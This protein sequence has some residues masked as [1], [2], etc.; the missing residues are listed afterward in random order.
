MALIAALLCLLGWFLPLSDY[1]TPKSGVG[2]WMGI[3]GASM[4]LLLLTY[5]L[6]KRYRFLDW[7]P[8]L[9][10]WFNLHIFLG[11]Y[12]PLLIL[13][14]CGYHL[15]A[16]N[17]NMALWSMITVAVSGVIGRFLYNRSEFKRAFSIWHVA[18]L[19]F[20]FMLAAA[21]IVHIIAVNMY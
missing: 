3:V 7:T 2:Y 6:R 10:K 12:G 11:L 9:G 20:V 1:L 8:P 4:M 17:S 19:P 14:H 5:S 16:F 13:Y 21:A 15:G 18:H